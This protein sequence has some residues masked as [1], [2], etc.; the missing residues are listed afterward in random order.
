M[1]GPRKNR[2][3]SDA[4]VGWFGVLT[5]RV[6]TLGTVGA[7][8]ALV[9][10]I[11]VFDVISGH[12]YTANW[13]SW[14]WLPGMVAPLVVLFKCWRPSRATSELRFIVL[15]SPIVV[16]L[17][18]GIWA[19]WWTFAV[20]AITLLPSVVWIRRARRY[21]RRSVADGQVLAGSVEGAVVSLA[22]ASL[23]KKLSEQQA[24]PSPKKRRRRGR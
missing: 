10:F 20:A 5:L 9:V 19:D 13:P 3:L 17:Y 7:A 8:T 15:A 12:E 11:G 14:G 24:S 1:I 21:D 2:N 6:T 18:A 16:S 23:L 4:G 22:K